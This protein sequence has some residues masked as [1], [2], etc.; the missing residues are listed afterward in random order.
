MAAGA[1]EVNVLLFERCIHKHTDA[2]A[3]K[4]NV[5]DKLFTVS[6]VSLCDANRIHIFTIK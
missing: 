3:D 4:A 5:E 1:E 2:H 6:F